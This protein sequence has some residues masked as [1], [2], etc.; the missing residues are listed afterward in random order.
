MTT[1]LIIIA[2]TT[3]M[4]ALAF[5]KPDTVLYAAGGICLLVLAMMLWEYSFPIALIVGVA[6]FYIAFI[7][8]RIDRLHKGGK[9]SG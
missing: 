9:A 4:N 1:L 8:Y 7:K 6:G 2:V 5:W 3:M